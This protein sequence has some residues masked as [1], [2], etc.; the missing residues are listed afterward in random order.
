[1]VQWVE[2]ASL[3]K[4]HR[5]L[6]VSE[7]ECHCEVLLTLK[8]LADVRW[9]PAPYCLSIIPHSLPLEIV[10]EKHFVTSDLLSLLAGSAPSTGDLEAEVSHREQ[11]LRASFVPWTSTSGD[12]SSSS[13]GPG[14][15]ERGI[16]PARLLLPRKG[17]G[18][19]PQVSK[20]RKKGTGRVNSTPKAQVEDFI[21]WV[22]SDPSQPSTSE[23]EEEEEEMTRLLDWYAARK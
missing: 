21:P 7:Q 8:N 6:E 3:E 4:I 20:I 11:V 15:D 2:K 13:P 9:S 19:V 18:P 22:C 14:R 5:L 10:V 1:M 17:T 23:E 16:S 12:F